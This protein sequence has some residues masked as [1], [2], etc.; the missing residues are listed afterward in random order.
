VRDAGKFAMSGPMARLTQILWKY[1][2]V[3][4]PL[5]WAAAIFAFVM[6][7][8]PH[9]PDIPGKPSDKI[10]H[11][12]AFVTLSLLGSWAFPRLSLIQLL[13]RLSLFGA[14]IELVQAIPVLHRDSDPLDWIADTIA[15]V[16]VLAVIAWGRGRL[17]YR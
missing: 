17:R 1:H 9:P 5:F 7:A 2:R 6:A 3:A 16:A 12:A 14:F 13:V 4:Q 8:M 10:Q 15:C 11:I